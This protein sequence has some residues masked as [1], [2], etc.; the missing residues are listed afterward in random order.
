MKLQEKDYSRQKE[1][2]K[3]S[4][5]SLLMVEALNNNKGGKI[6]HSVSGEKELLLSV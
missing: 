4:K 2:P 1:I 3:L 5:K 6:C